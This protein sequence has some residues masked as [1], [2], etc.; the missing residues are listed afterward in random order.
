[1]ASGLQS[2]LEHR[3]CVLTFDGRLFM[4][5]LIAFDQSTNIVLNKCAEKV[6]HEDAPVEIVPLGLYLL[7]GDNI[8]VVGQV[9]EDVEKS[10]DASGVRA[11]PLKPI[12]HS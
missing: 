8:A 9:D 11:P 5:T 12:K 3:V 6:V 1:M 2:L 7:R 10:I 4:G